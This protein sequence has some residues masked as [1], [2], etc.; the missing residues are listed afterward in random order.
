VFAF[1]EM[2]SYLILHRELY[3]QERR[4]KYSNEE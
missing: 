2:K 1:N 4:N 3:E